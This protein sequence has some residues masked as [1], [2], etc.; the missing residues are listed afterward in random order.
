MRGRIWLIVGA[1]AGIAI[2]AGRLPYLAGAGRTLAATAERLVLS[3]ADRI[4]SAA[5]AAGA[6][7]RV[8]LGFGSL[9][10]VVLPG[11]TALLLVVAARA[12]LRIR[13]I[14]AVLVVA[15]G[16]ASYLY[17]PHG[18]A[19]GVLVLALAFAGLAVTLSGP[20]L[21]APL[22]LGA[23]LI[24]AEYLPT[25]VSNGLSATRTSVNAMHLALFNS[26]GTPTGLEV[27]LLIVAAIPFAWAAR[28]ILFR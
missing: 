12:T 13:A 16:A 9:I 28:L 14:I 19:T 24:G 17:H 25:L 11:L 7:K 5:A 22:A 8:V 23:G 2:A 10:A 21:V 20:L 1:A 4:I 27:A 3:G 26:P 18:N 15:L 6:S